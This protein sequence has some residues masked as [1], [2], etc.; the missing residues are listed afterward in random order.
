TEII[1]SIISGGQVYIQSKN[2]SITKLLMFIEKNKITN[3]GCGPSLLYL[4]VDNKHLLKKYDM[5]SLEEI[6]IGYEKCNIKLI[7]NLQKILPNVDFINGYGTTETFAA[8]TFY[9][10]PNLLENS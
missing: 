4:L 8:S 6:Y 3:L 2:V 7:K 5:S 10:I 9:V 1:P